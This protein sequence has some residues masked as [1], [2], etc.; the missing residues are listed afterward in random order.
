MGKEQGS[1]AT[2]S[3]ELVEVSPDDVGQLSEIIA[4]VEV[5]ETPQEVVEEKIE[6][7]KTPKELQ[8]RFLTLYTA[9]KPL[10]TRVDHSPNSHRHHFKPLSTVL[11]Y[12]KSPVLDIATS[13]KGKKQVRERFK[14]TTQGLVD[15]D[16]NSVTQKAI[17]TKV[18][19]YKS[20]RGL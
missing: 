8:R 6:M 2:S 20:A 17:I 11:F 1:K 10:S 15:S 12:G 14:L 4:P 7:G 18:K 13:I 9:I 19:V 3:P 16:G 5:V